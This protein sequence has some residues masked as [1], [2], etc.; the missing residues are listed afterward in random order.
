[1]GNR[2]KQKKEMVKFGNRKMKKNFV[3]WSLEFL[4]IEKQPKA[5]PPLMA[6]PRINRRILRHISE[7]TQRR[8][9]T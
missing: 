8:G 4:A 9:L 6:P 3:A 1:M 7:C 5:M 2:P